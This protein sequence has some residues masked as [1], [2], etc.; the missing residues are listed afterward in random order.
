MDPIFLHSLEFALQNHCVH[1]LLLQIQL[2]MMKAS[3]DYVREN[4]FS[5]IIVVSFGIRLYFCP[6][7]MFWTCRSISKYFFIFWKI[8]FVCNGGYKLN[9]N[10][11]VT[12]R[13][14]YV[15]WKP[16]LHKKSKYRCVYSVSV[17]GK[18]MFVPSAR[19]TFMERWRAADRA[20]EAA[21]SR[22][23]F[24]LTPDPTDALKYEWSHSRPTLK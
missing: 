4:C 8:N 11:D 1:F 17:N 6:I 12:Q 19:W 5:S 13:I 20:S 18:P 23:W 14:F 24:Q 9:K 16:D 3:W 10:L 15:L 2:R 7:N 21:W 22:G